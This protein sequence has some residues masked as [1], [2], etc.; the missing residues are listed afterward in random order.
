MRI[1]LL[2]PENFLIGRHGG[3]S[4]YII[5]LAHSLS[6]NNQEVT[7]LVPGKN[8]SKQVGN[9]WVYAR[10][11]TPQKKIT[12]FIRVKNRIKKVV[13]KFLPNLLWRFEWNKIVWNFIQEKKTFDIIESPEW[14]NGLLLTK[15]LNKNQLVVT[16]LHRSTFIYKLD[17]KL[18]INFDDRLTNLW[19]MLATIKSTAITSPNKFM[20]NRYKKYLFFHKKKA[21]IIKYGITI[22]P[23]TSNEKTTIPKPYILFVGRIEKAK[24]SFNLIQ[25][26]GQVHH[27]F[28]NLNLVLVGEDTSMEINGK[29]QSYKA[30]L[31][32]YCVTHGYNK[33]V[34]FVQKQNQSALQ[35]FY[36]HAA[37]VVVPSIGNENQP[38]VI[39]EAIAQNKALVASKTGGIPE[40][41]KDGS[42]GLLC[43][44][45]DPNDLAE[46]I[47]L[48]LK[49]NKLKKD[50]EINNKL[51]KKN[52]DV[53]KNGKKTLDFYKELKQRQ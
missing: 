18:P 10:N 17:N 15:V 49:N 34:F 4:T 43:K 27:H 29:T 45:N 30:F 39:L 35:S 9:F 19:E 1:L 38:L 26:F 40:I 46:K 24:G 31:K 28:P 37:F 50:I 48:L 2:C 36:K 41:I 32:K 42:N 20:I 8:H 52:Y 11:L 47:V 23:K 12:N 16:K 22:N 25:A 14:C 51:L 7:V 53:K 5:N 44:P 21:T 6:Q 3:V 33:S 13:A